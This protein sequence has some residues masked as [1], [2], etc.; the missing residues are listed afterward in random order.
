M[1]VGQQSRLVLAETY[2]AWARVAHEM[3]QKW[4]HAQKAGH[5]LVGNCERL[6]LAEVLG[7]WRDLLIERKEAERQEKADHERRILKE[8]SQRR[9]LATLGGGA[10]LMKTN[11]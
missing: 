6:I 4:R 3:R 5:L 1:F 8:E 7:H 2:A 9:V 11:V 10:N